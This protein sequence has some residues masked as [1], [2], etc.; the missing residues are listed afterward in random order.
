MNSSSVLNIY[1]SQKHW[2]GAY[3]MRIVLVFFLAFISVNLV[4]QVARYSV[5]DG[6]WNNTAS[7]S[8]TS[9][10][11]SGASVP[12]AGDTVYIEEGYIISITGTE[13]CDS[14][15]IFGNFGGSN[16]ELIV[17]GGTLNVYGGMS[18]SG[19][20]GTETYNKEGKF[21]V[22]NSGT[23]TVNGNVYMLSDDNK[24]KIEVL[25]AGD[26]LTINGDVSLTSAGGDNAELKVTD[27]TLSVNGDIYFLG[28]LQED[29]IKLM[30]KGTAT[31]NF[32][33]NIDRTAAG[34]FGEI[35]S[36]PGSVFNFNGTAPQIMSMIDYGAFTR[37]W[38]YGEV[39][40]NN[41]AGVT[42]DANVTQ[43]TDNNVLDDIR[44][45]S[46]TFNTGGF[47]VLLADG[48]EFEVANGATYST[49]TT[50]ATGG[51]P[52]FVDVNG[53][54]TYADNSTVIFAASG[55]QTI[56]GMTAADADDYG[57]VTISGTGTKTLAHPL[58]D[59]YDGGSG[60]IDLAGDL[61][62][63]GTATFDVVSYNITVAGDWTNTGTFNE[64]TQMVTFDGTSQQ[65]IS[66]AALETFYDLTVNN[67]NDV[68]LSSGDINI[69]N[70]LT[71][72][73]GRIN[74]GANNLVIAS[75]GSILGA[76]SSRYIISEGSGTLTQQVAAADKIFP[77][78]TA[79]SYVPITLNNTGGTPDNYSILVFSDILTNGTSGSTISEIAECVYM[80]WVVS[81]GTA[82]G[83]NLS[84]TLQWNSGDEGG[85]FD[86]AD[87]SIGIHNGSAWSPENSAG[88]AGSDP[89]T[90]TR[91]GITEVGAFAVGN[92]CTRM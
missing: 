9:G 68:I 88:A 45:Q 90:K 89:Y 26:E 7:W 28:A 57:N 74:L 43:T 20:G 13:A 11:A 48:N 72:T 80:T 61:T 25:S 46:G 30:V 85:S 21:K 19:D 62:I 71:L 40:I 8:A 66:V 2:S 54:Y 1:P 82:N 55:D 52:T 69:D 87:C 84:A 4:A 35:D 64:G 65:S 3:L 32:T 53:I 16:S 49:T 78:G 51:I 77:V 22:D 70:D 31:F 24:V 17:D 63:N 14:V 76:S 10:G 86:N 18:L 59:A 47:S 56:P 60:D 75:T 15:I 36:D 23:A 41:T 83:S 27:G 12:V 37:R 6:N 58:N 44:V 38:E 39:R 34:N 79:G 42:L 29:D 33:G 81:E 91:S 92:S 67:A 50:D 5:N 73:S